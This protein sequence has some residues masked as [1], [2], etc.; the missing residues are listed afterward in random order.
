MSVTEKQFKSNGSFSS[1][2]L[3]LFFLRVLCNLTARPDCPANC[4]VKIGS[5]PVN[6]VLQ[7]IW[8]LS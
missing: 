2:G 5:V 1:G 3:L 8:S 6:Q 7:S 4:V